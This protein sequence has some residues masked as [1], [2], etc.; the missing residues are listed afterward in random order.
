MNGVTGRVA[1]NEGW[2]VGTDYAVCGKTS[3]FRKGQLP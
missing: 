3:P 2:V 1:I